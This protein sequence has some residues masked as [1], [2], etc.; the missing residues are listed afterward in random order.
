M[1]FMFSKI[2][3]VWQVLTHIFPDK[4]SIEI[5]GDYALI[6]DFW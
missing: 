6:Y 2:N 5:A 1:Y 3:S 4:D